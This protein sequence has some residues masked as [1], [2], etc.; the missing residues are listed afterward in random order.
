MTWG[1]V[2]ATTVISDQCS[3]RGEASPLGL[4]TDSRSLWLRLRR[5]RSS[6]SHPLPTS[7]GITPPPLARADARRAFQL[8]IPRRASHNSPQCSQ[9]LS[10]R[11]RDREWVSLE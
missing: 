4:F 5:P 9:N 6:A 2:A 11:S 1:G 10:S 8:T 7:G 3:V